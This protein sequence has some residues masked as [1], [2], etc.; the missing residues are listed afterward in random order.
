MLLNGKNGVSKML[1]F[2]Q[3]W[4]LLAEFLGEV[5]T[6]TQVFLSEYHQMYVLC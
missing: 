1:F 6:F 2:L 4:L 3:K 5:K